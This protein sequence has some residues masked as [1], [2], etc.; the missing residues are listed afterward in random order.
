MV[1]N[2]AADA[3]SKKGTRKIQRQMERELQR[4]QSEEDE[5]A[6]RKKEQERHYQ[7]SLEMHG[8]LA[9]EFC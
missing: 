1:P 2:W 3:L 6:L 8:N 4:Y 5:V 9:R 7:A